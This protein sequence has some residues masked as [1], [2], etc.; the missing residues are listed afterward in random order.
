MQLIGSPIIILIKSSSKVARHFSSLGMLSH[1]FLVPGITYAL[2]KNLSFSVVLRL[3]VLARPSTRHSSKH[4]FLPVTLLHSGS[5]VFTLPLLPPRHTP[6]LPYT[7]CEIV[8][9]APSH[10]HE[11]LVLC[12]TSSPYHTL[13]PISASQVIPPYHTSSPMSTHNTFT[14][15]PTPTRSLTLITAISTLLHASLPYSR[16]IHSPSLPFILA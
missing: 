15:T 12:C 14:H 7:H 9:P 6:N 2:L 10:S 16:Q 4:S 1:S 11:S 13:R 8:P 5:H 3:L